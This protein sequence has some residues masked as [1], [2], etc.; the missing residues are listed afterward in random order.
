MERSDA[1]YI[2]ELNAPEDAYSIAA[3]L[4]DNERFAIDSIHSRTYEEKAASVSATV[5]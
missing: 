4:R 3:L 1:D 2:I 5:P